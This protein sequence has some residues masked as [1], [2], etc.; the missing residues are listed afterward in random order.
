VLGGVISP[1]D[2]IGPDDLRISS[3][4]IRLRD[5][6]VTE[7]IIATAPNLEGEAAAVFLSRLLVQ[8]GFATCE[9][10]ARRRRPRVRRRGHAWPGF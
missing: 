1:I 8:P 10:L 6:T 3:L 9:R 2:G 4:L 7:V 5:G